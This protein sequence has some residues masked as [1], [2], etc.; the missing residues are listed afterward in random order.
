MM[1]VEIFCGETQNERVSSFLPSN[2]FGA[3]HGKNRGRISSCNVQVGGSAGKICMQD[4]KN[5]I[6]LL[7]VGHQR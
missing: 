1:I 5:M 3:Y 2:R 4:I 6:Y 7:S